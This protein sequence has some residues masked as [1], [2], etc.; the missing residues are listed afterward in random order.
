MSTADARAF[1]AKTLDNIN[2]ATFDWDN[3]E[4]VELLLDIVNML[5]AEP[6]NSEDQ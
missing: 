2:G 3:D 5:G 6:T 4:V 1:I